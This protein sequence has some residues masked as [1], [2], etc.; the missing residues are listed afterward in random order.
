MVH[1]IA[2]LYGP[3][4]SA[5]IFFSLTALSSSSSSTTSASHLSL[6][7]HSGSFIGHNCR[8]RF[9]FYW[10]LSSTQFTP[11]EHR[12]LAL[13]KSKAIYCRLSNP[14]KK[15]FHLLT[16][17]SNIGRDLGCM[18][19]IPS[20]AVPLL[21]VVPMSVIFLIKLLGVRGKVVDCTSPV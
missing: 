7:N 20:C 19:R 11:V 10:I 3:D 2:V 14:P 4:S 21:I 8:L 17:S 15:T 18:C 16:R 6:K 12:L 13:L 5:E 1:R 9:Q